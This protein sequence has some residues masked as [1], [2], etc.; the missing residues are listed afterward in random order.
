M[1]GVLADGVT[2]IP[3]MRSNDC[4]GVRLKVRDASLDG[5]CDFLNTYCIGKI[6]VVI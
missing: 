2:H 6:S 5:F 1:V 3:L 4:D